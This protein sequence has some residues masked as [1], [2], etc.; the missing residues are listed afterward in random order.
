LTD[1][2]LVAQVIAYRNDVEK[3]QKQR[4]NLKRA[5][6]QLDPKFEAHLIAKAKKVK[7]MCA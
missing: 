1:T 2:E 4:A 7:Q 5:A 6:G 3:K